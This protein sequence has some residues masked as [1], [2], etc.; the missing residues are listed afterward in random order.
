MDILSHAAEFAMSLFI[1]STV[2]I[3]LSGIYFIQIKIVSDTSMNPKVTKSLRRVLYIS[4]TF[5]TVVLILCG[6][7]FMTSVETTVYFAMIAFL[8]QIYF[9][10]RPA[11]TYGRFP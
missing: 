8:L 5:G 2:L 6:A 1:A 3:G 4:I 7:W 9:F 11:V 10:V